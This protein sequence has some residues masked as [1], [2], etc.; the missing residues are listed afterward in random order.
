MSNYNPSELF[1]V[2]LITVY[3]KSS[4]NL[5]QQNDSCELM[6]QSNTA[7]GKAEV[8]AALD[9]RAEAEAAADHEV[10]S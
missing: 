3:F 10:D 4:V 2:G 9:R 1:M 6:W 5:F 7:K 8:G